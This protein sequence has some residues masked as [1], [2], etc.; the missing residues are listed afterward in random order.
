MLQAPRTKRQQSTAAVIEYIE[1]RLGV[2]GML[3]RS[4]YIRYAVQAVLVY[5][6]QDDQQSTQ[7]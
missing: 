7:T 4:L 3:H 2:E 6:Q 1:L 5:D